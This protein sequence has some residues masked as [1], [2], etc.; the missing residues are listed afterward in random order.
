M[1][2]AARRH[3]CSRWPFQCGSARRIGKEKQGSAHNKPAGMHASEHKLGS[4]QQQQAAAQQ[5][6]GRRH[7][8]VANH[9]ACRC[10]C[11]TAGL[12]PSCIRGLGQTGSAGSHSATAMHHT[13]VDRAAG[14]GPVQG[15]AVVRNKQAA[16]G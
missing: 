16:P 14:T 5:R 11:V 13:P 2:E 15:G 12:V 8:R 10:C 3:I 9:A 1:E 6:A 7:S 4:M